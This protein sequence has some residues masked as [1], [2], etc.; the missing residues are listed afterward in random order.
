MF[1]LP[2]PAGLRLGAS[3]FRSLADDYRDIGRSAMS[4]ANAV[5][6]GS[7]T[8]PPAEACRTVL[9]RMFGEVVT[10]HDT[11][12]DVAGRLET[13]AAAVERVRGRHG[14]LLSEIGSLH[15]SNPVEQ[16]LRLHSLD[17]EL[18]QL[19]SVVRS[20]MAHAAAGIRDAVGAAQRAGDEAHRNNFFV[21][22]GS[23]FTDTATSLTT[24]FV[25]GT[26]GLITGVVGILE[27]GV[28]LSP[29]RLLLDP[30]GFL[31]DA[32]STATT[33][34]NVY[35]AFRQDPG[36]MLSATLDLDLLASDPARW[37]GRAVPD[38]ILAIA[39]TGAGTAIEGGT[40]GARIASGL[41]NT[42][43]RA[44]DDAA[45]AARISRATRLREL[46]GDPLTSRVDKGWIQ[47]ELTR[48]TRG[49]ASYLRNPPGS[50]LV[51]MRGLENAKGVDHRFSRLQDRD[52]HRLQHRHDWW[53]RRN[54]N[55]SDTPFEDYL[56]SLRDQLIGGNSGP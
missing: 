24:G 49:Q 17:R 25:E 7:W 52:L 13:V 36:A 20:Q 37:V 55:M 4:L 10:A 6:D 21:Q 22:L 41:G 18:R 1:V 39:T 5:G 45:R 56:E 30:E 43:L 54:P 44:S 42:A 16:A 8:G 31:A 51:H 9:Q 2:D 3:S 47:Q 34:A 27:L 48:R 35:S 40:R 33:V 53:G 15:A 38:V 46:L 11:M 26:V 12:D 28:R 50:D 23:A 14:T 29:A 32:E 19:E